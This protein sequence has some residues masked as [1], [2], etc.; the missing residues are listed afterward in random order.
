MSAKHPGYV[1][2]RGADDRIGAAD[3]GCEGKVAFATFELAKQV[4][5]RHGHNERPRQPYRCRYC[6][7]F[8]LGD[9]RRKKVERVLHEAKN[10]EAAEKLQRGD[11]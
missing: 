10:R 9:V 8:H 4:A 5:D 3:A 2:R 6:R 1:G 11:S 7:S